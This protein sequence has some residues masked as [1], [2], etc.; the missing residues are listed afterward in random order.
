MPVRRRRKKRSA[1]E[2]APAFGSPVPADIEF[3]YLLLPVTE[4]L[5]GDEI[6]SFNET[7]E[8]FEYNRVR[9]VADMGV[10]EVY[11][12]KTASGRVIRTTAEHP[13]LARVLEKNS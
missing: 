7:S 8:E 6:L 9:Q 5:P 13:F 12:L 4:I 2:V 10:Q 11:E 3:D 1:P